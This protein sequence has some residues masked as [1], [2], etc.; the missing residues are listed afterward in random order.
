MDAILHGRPYWEPGKKGP[1]VSEQFLNQWGIYGNTVGYAEPVSLFKQ[2]VKLIADLYNKREIAAQKTQ[3][4]V[5][6]VEWL[7][8]NKLAKR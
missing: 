7:P 4:L 8:L 2:K 1:W 3:K 5:Q 6:L